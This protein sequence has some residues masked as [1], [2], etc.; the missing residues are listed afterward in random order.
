MRCLPL[1]NRFPRNGLQLS[2][3]S[4]PASGRLA[5]GDEIPQ[6]FDSPTYRI[7]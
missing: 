6:E 3:Q 2:N 5:E 4:P 1:F 7:G